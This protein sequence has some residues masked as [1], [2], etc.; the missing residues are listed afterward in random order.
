MS[1]GPNH[2]LRY[3]VNCSTLF[4]ELPLLQRPAAARA[5]GFDAIELW[6]PWASPAPPDDEVDALIAAVDGAGVRLVGLNFYGGDLSGADAGV[7]S[8]PG[9]EHEFR[10]NVAV[11][12][13]IAGRLGAVVMNALYGVRVVGVSAEEQDELA[14]TNLAFAS[15]AARSANITV[16]LEPLSGPKPY[17]LRTARDALAVI[18][19]L[20]ESGVAG[21]AVLA[22]LYHLAVNGDDLD[23]L[24]EHVG[25]IGHL[26]IADVPGRGEPGSG[27]LDWARIVR[28]VERNGYTGWLSLEYLPTAGTDASLAWLPRSRRGSDVAAPG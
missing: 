13:A 27:R 25:E 16:V 22:D 15:A 23:R 6:W 26:Q 3:A 18:Q 5:A 9:R 20:R 12:V 10:D 14:L 24:S 4:T 28:G 21:I 1:A 2:G 19:R 7:V 8:V 17:P 11:A